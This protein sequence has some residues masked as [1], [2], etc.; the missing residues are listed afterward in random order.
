MFNVLILKYGRSGTLWEGRF[1]SYLIQE[2][3][4]LLEVYRYIELNPVRAEMVNDPGEYRR[5]SYPING[6]GKVSDLCTPHQEYLVW[7]KKPRNDWKHIVSLFLIKLMVNY[8]LPTKN[9][10][11]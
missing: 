1:K 7:A 2:E 3:D 9:L 8:W 10:C 6:F 5:P 11:K 4:Y